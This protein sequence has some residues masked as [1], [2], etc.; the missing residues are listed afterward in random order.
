LRQGRLHLTLLFAVATSL[1]LASP[2]GAATISSSTASPFDDNF[3]AD[4]ACS[5]REMVQI[6]NTNIATVEDDCTVDTDGGLDPL[7]DDTIQLQGGMYMLTTPLGA[8]DITNGDLEVNDSANTLTL[9]GQ[10]PLATQINGNSHDR[11]LDIAAASGEVTVEDLTIFDGQTPANGGGI[12]TAADLTLQGARV[13]SNQ[14][15]VT[16]GGIQATGAATEVTL[17]DSTV[18]LN[19]AGSSGGGVN[20]I[21]ASLT[22]S[23]DSHINDNDAL[24]GGGINGAGPG[25]ADITLGPGVT[26]NGNDVVATGA[27]IAHN[28]NTASVN[29]TL[30]GAVVSGNHATSGSQARGG[31]INFFG[32][33]SVQITDSRIQNNTVQGPQASGGGIHA[34]MT[35]ATPLVIDRSLLSGNSVTVL[36]DGAAATDHGGGG[37]STPVAI[38][39]AG[40]VDVTDSLFTGNTVTVND[41]QD[42]AVGGAISSKGE[43][44]VDSSTFEGN[45]TAGTPFSSQ[46]GAIDVLQPAGP[47]GI[48]NSTFSNNQLVATADLND[49]GGAIWA[50]TPLAAPATIAHST[51][52]DNDAPD[53]G[54][55]L[56]LGAANYTVRGSVFAETGPATA[57]VP[58]GL[59]LNGAGTGYNVDVGDTCAGAVDDDDIETILADLGPLVANGGPLYGQAGLALTHAL[60]GPAQAIDYVPAASCD[61]LDGNPLVVDQRGAPRQ[62]G[63]DC[64]PGA[65]E[66]VAC[67]GVSAF[68]GSASGDTID[69][70][71]IPSH[72]SFA[73][74][75]GGDTLNGDADANQ[76][77]GGDGDDTITGGAGSD[78]LA[79]D[80]DAD[81]IFARDGVADTITCGTG[82]DSVET[83]LAGVDA[84]NPDCENVDF[85]QPVTTNPP[86]TTGED[87]GCEP[88]RQ[89]IKKL[90]KKIKRADG[91]ARSKLKKKRSKARKQLAALGC[92]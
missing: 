8:D 18:D 65:Y 61:G 36:D 40:L 52:T 34:A 3:T 86:P 58:D 16:G 39:G 27:G 77:C 57:C 82:T 72:N 4:F 67:N 70:V 76:L 17:N 29:V 46:G 1:L 62:A 26:V 38:A 49:S 5:L 91:S 69:A 32:G 71:S 79:G 13:T 85:V 66:I 35:G 84:I 78:T 19:I 22:A 43:L 88:L 42:F 24:A 80:A 9:S 59:P 81:T 47:T 56:T 28:A 11:V 41:P 53:S 92:P 45:G 89:K 14:A 55:S 31:G 68:V 30:T 12:V 37:L 23:G 74:L 48:V 10:G 64:E 25:D 54:A 15:S 75:G 87:P 51:F 50:A 21:G 90:S 83:D 73:G 44:T 6:A 33:G 7:G 60:L 63:D 2:A 20:L